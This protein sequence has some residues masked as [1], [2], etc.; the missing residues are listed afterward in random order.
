M[1]VLFYLFVATVFGILLL[2]GIAIWAP[3]KAW[4]RIAAV[5]LAVTMMPL[6]YMAYSGLLSK[7]KPRQLAWLERNVEKAFILGASFDEGRAIY[8][9]LRLEGIAEPRYYAL[10]WHQDTAEKLQDEIEEATKKNGGIMVIKPFT[11]DQFAQQ[12]GLNIKIVP[13]PVLP[14]KPPRF[15]DRIIN[16]RSTDI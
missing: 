6:G 5:A 14:M 8:L 16:P 3:R 1:D 2:S 11:N 4:I 7:P 13:P 9:W 10:P 15:P 12:G